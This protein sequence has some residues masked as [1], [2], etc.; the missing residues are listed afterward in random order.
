MPS[1]SGLACAARRI[2][3]LAM[4]MASRT[5]CSTVPV[6]RS[7]RARTRCT[8]ISAA[9]S[10]AA[11]PPMPSTTKKMPRSASIWNASSLLLR[12]R[13]GSLAPALLTF[14]LT[15]R[16]T[17]ELQE[18][19]ARQANARARR[20]RRLQVAVALFAAFHFDAG[21]RLRAVDRRAQL[22]QVLEEKLPARRVAAQA[23]V[24]A[25][26][27]G[28]R[29]QLDVGPVIAP[30]AADHDFVLGHAVGL[31][32]GA[33]FVLDHRE[34][35]GVRRWRGWRGWRGRRRIVAL[36]GGLHATQA[37]RGDALGHG[38]RPEFVLGGQG[39]LRGDGDIAR[40][41]VFVGVFQDANLPAALRR[42]DLRARAPRQF[43]ALAERG[44]VQAFDLGIERAARFVD[45]SRQDAAQTLHV[46]GMQVD[47]EDGRRQGGVVQ[48]LETFAHVA[49]D[50]QDDV[51]RGSGFG[52]G[53]TVHRGSN[54]DFNSPRAR[55]ASDGPECRVG[56]MPPGMGPWQPE[57][58]RYGASLTQ[59]N[60]ISIVE[61]R[62][63]TVKMS[64]RPPGSSVSSARKDWPRIMY[65]GSPAVGGASFSFLKSLENLSR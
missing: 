38:S 1:N 44:P 6:C 62:S 30:P 27:V 31:A 32:A 51:S 61:P 56:R 20:H 13:P 53:R 46:A 24:F 59:R 39:E 63:G 45:D 60:P 55:Y 7:R 48:R 22:A 50:L 8:A 29:F 65:H 52:G 64:Q 26:H 40:L 5:R 35:T 28:Q 18:H 37:A 4:V 47:V 9:F 43:Q 16:C 33:V 58:L 3:L 49:D 19:H 15:I 14:V 12:T 54:F 57:R 36:F 11:C 23:E 42:H 41:H 25:R 10:P 34:R 21:G 17:S 2:S